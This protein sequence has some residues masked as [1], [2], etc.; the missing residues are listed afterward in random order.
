MAVARFLWFVT[1]FL[2]VVAQDWDQLDR[3]L[4]EYIETLWQ[5]G[6]PRSWAADVLSGAQHMLRVTCCAADPFPRSR[7]TTS[8]MMP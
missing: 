4:C 3:Q 6:E 7:W 8:R 1:S 5:E 2:N